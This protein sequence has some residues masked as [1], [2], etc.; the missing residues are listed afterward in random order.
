MTPRTARVRRQTNVDIENKT[1]PEADASRKKRKRKGRAPSTVCPTS[2][3]LSRFPWIRNLLDGR[4]AEP[5]LAGRVAAL[6]RPK[7]SPAIASRLRFA[8]VSLFRR[9]L[10]EHALAVH[11]A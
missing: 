4:A 6:S 3:P 5:S 8:R 1:L 11:Y 7:P 2:F 9:C 10:E